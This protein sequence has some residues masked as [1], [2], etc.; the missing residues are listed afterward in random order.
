MRI[1]TIG[2]EGQVARS[3]REAARENPDIVIGWGARPDVDILCPKLVR[4]A[5]MDFSPDIVVNPAAYT[6]V[7]PCGSR[8]RTCLRNQSRWS[9][10]GCECRKAIRHSDRPLV[11]GLCF[12]RQKTQFLC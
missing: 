10:Y 4:R 3:L 2:R 7:D 12:R 5:L 1:Y 8:T 6:A 9:R 11:D